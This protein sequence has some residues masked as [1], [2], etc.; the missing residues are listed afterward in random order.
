[1]S[2]MNSDSHLLEQTKG[3]LQDAHKCALGPH[4]QVPFHSVPSDQ[5]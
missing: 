4:M 2:T 3:A 1:M 5:W